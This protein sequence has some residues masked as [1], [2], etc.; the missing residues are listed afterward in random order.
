MPTIG[1]GTFYVRRLIGTVPIEE[2]G[3]AH[4]TAP[5]LRDISFNALDAEGRVIQKMGS[6]TQVMSGEHQSCVG[7]HEYEKAPPTKTSFGPLAARRAPSTPARPDWDTGGIIDY[8]LV[9][10]PVW[11]KHYTTQSPSSRQSTVAR[12]PGA[13]AGSLSNGL[14]PV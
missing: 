4:F 13:L 8:C 6:S 7:C 11:D 14:P 1:R 5:A 3:S 9:V 12:P 2:D 10:Q